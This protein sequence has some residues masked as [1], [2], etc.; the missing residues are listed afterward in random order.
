MRIL[1]DTNVLIDVYARRQPFEKD[2]V[3][4]IVMSVLG[5]AELWATSNSFTDVFFV[6]QKTFS[7]GEIK[8]M[9][10]R[11]FEWINVCSV[12]SDDVKRALSCRWPDFE[13]CIVDVCAKKIKADYVLT[14]DRSGF[15]FSKEVVLD[16]EGFFGML[17]RDLGLT[18]GS[19]DW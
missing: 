8:G 7:S 13:D 3:R 5:D 2:A 17:E 9:I 19:V 4:L 12:D 14:R 16:P 10:E 1:L 15:A 18:Y 11:S 6:L